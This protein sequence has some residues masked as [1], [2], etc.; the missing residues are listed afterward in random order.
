MTLNNRQRRHLRGLTHSLQP[1]VTVADKG[2]SENVMSELETALDHHELV[3]VKLR[4]DRETR[5]RWIEE[6]ERSCGAVI[7]HRIGQVA[8]FYRQNREKPVLELP[9]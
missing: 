7:V 9:E 6:I 4:S 8:S 1:V 2:L 5:N 3:K